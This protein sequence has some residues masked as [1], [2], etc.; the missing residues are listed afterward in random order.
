VPTHLTKASAMEMHAAL[1][2]LPGPIWIQ[3]AT[4]N[5]ASA[6]LLVHLA[7]KNGWDVAKTFAYGKANAYKCMSAEILR[8]WIIAA[9]NP[10]D[11]KAISGAQADDIIIRQLFDYVS[12]PLQPDR[13]LT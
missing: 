8:N 12:A 11:A 3:C 4:A 5:R 9:L 13:S 1:S 7:M 6:V 2:A 10:T